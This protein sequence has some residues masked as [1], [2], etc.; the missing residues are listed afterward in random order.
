MNSRSQAGQD[1]FVNALHPQPGTFLD[2][3]AAGLAISN[4]LGLE[5]IGWTG[6]LVDNSPEA[7]R[8]STVRKAW[9]KLADATQRDYSF[10]PPIVDFLSLDVDG[11]S[12]DALRKIFASAPKTSFRT[13]TVEHDQ[14]ERGE[15]LRTPMLELLRAKGY[16]ILCPDVCHEGKSFE[17]WA[18]KPELVDMTVAEKFRRDKPTDWKEILNVDQ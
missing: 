18:V 12:L 9:F 1:R 10:L 8:A 6:I 4:T 15:S 11:A 5:E 13:I 3:G 17:I 7:A 14:Y 2:I 16:D